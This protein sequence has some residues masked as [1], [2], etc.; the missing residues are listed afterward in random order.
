MSSFDS[1]I[2]VSL[3][4]PNCDELLAMIERV[5]PANALVEIRFDALE[6]AEL[7]IGSNARLASLTAKIAAGIP[8]NRVLA[9]FRPKS[10]GGFREL[11]ATDRRWF[12]GN[13][14]F[15]AIHDFEEDVFT[16]GT[17]AV[18]IVSKHDF[19][20]VPNDLDEIF[21]RLVS[22]GADI[23]K[24]AYQATDATDAI[25]A[26]RLLELA[27]AD[28]S[29]LV[30]IAMGECGKLTRIL[31]PSRGAPMSYASAASFAG[32]APGQISADDLAGV[33]RIGELS[34]KTE[35]Y[36]ILGSNT[37]VSMSP[38]IH[39]AAFAHHRLDKVFAPLQTFDLDAFMTR[40]VRRETREI[41]LNF[42][43]F[44]VTIPHKQAI[45]AHLDEIDE[46]AA[47]IGAVNTVR[48][49]DGRLTGFN[50]DA[51]GFIEPLLNSFGDVKNARVALIGA[52]GAARA[53][54]YA[55][56]KHGA[57]VTVFARDASKA[58]S[59]AAEFGA[60][61][62]VFPCAS[63]RDFD[64]L[65]N[66]TPLGMTG[67]GDGQTPATA[68]ELAGL[69]L[70]YDL[71]YVPFQTPL[72]DEADKAEVPKIGGFAMLLAQALEQQRIWT[73]LEPPAEIMA[74]AALERLR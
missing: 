37:S 58:E 8:S 29:R 26:F 28:E 48:I 13:L 43:G 67:K 6:P 14:D 11:S 54:V 2:C 32:T 15:G 52:G 9:T 40:M 12:H 56:R 33:Y 69:D 16:R 55:L 23:V 38:Y 1:K 36:G 45:I 35:V 64:I 71:V 70:V 19:E 65:V 3:A 17:R 47:M 74:R 46:T 42:R 20:G 50:T 7:P 51:P 61:H 59:L 63:Y 41:D 30:P 34:E 27:K 66:S 21:A 24:I 31:G 5:R 10:E 68:A 22:T 18:S 72:M 53:C 73:G 44:S 39:N 49:D 25:P 62:A 4:A 57:N 60:A